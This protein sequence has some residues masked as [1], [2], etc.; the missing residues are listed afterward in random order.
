MIPNRV[1]AGEP[2][3]A[4]TINDIIDSLNRLSNAVNASPGAVNAYRL[5]SVCVN[6]D[7][8]VTISAGDPVYITTAST[9]LVNTPVLSVI[10]YDG[11]HD[12][13][14]PVGVARFDMNTEERGVVSLRGLAVMNV[15]SITTGAYLEPDADNGGFSFTDTPTAFRYV[16]RVTKADDT[17]SA[18]QVLAMITEDGSGGGGGGGE[19]A[20]HGYFTA[21]IVTITANG[22]TTQVIR[23]VNGDNPSAQ[24]CGVT[25][26]G[27]VNSADVAFQQ[28][29]TLYLYATYSN[30]A[31]TFGFGFSYPANSAW[32]VI[33][34][35]NSG[36]LSQVWTGGA[37]YFAE[38]YLI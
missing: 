11:T 31:Y 12:D 23:I 30:N 36:V 2:V 25:D 16:G 37:I 32:W 35:V 19:I 28:N 24:V 1:F 18:T 3:R 34:Q 13:E 7:A 4:Q 29:G 14:Y 5:A 26:L 6:A 15:S 33:A 27:N 9:W 10:P 8:E 17:S 21:R 22:Q 20:Y 38:R